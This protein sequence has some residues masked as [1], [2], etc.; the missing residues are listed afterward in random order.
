MA[1]KY[2][3]ITLRVGKAWVDDDNFKH[4][5]TWVKWSAI[6]KKDWGLVW[7]DD[8]T[9]LAPFDRFYYS[10]Y[11]AD[12]N[13]VGR[14]LATLQAS[15]VSQAKSSSSSMLSN[16]DWYVTRKSETN[17]AIPSGITAYRTAV[18][19]VMDMAL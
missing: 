12:G 1:W 4:P 18:R 2:G 14:T 16:T 6:E 8:P 17:T 19:Q 7:E 5:H 13:L 9:P 11:D 3:D 10:G 15:K